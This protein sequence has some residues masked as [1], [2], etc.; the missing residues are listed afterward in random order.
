MKAREAFRD[1]VA[2]ECECAECRLIARE[3]LVEADAV[4]SFDQPS[5]SCRRPRLRE[6]LEVRSSSACVTTTY[7]AG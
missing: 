3:R 5:M 6:C 4:R 2:F 7:T 1:P